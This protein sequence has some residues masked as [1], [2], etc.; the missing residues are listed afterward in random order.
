MK[1]SAEKSSATTSTTATQT[2]QHPF[3]GKS[4]RDSFFAPAGRTAAPAVQ[5]KMTL[6]KPGDK[7]EQ[8]ADKMADRV[9]RMPAPPAKEEKLQRQAEDRLPRQAMPEEKIRRKEEEKLQK[10]PAGDERLPRKG[11]DGAAPTVSD[12]VQS[13]VRSGAS[14]GG[15]PL[16]NEVRSYMEPRFGADFGNV[17][18]HNDAESAR[19]G[20]QL[21][22]RAFT[23]QNHVFFSRDQYQPGTSEGK[24]LLAHELGHTVQQGP[25]LQRQAAPPAA[26]RRE[27]P[28]PAIR[29]APAPA[30][31]EAVTSSEVVDLSSAGFNPSRKVSDEIEAQGHKGLDVRVMV[32]GLT[33][34][35]R[36]KTRSDRKGKN[37]SGKGSMP[38]LN[39][40]AE[41]LGGMHVNFVLKNGEVTGG[42][43][44]L[45]P[46]GGDTNDWLET[47][48][49]NSA[50]LGGPGLKVGSLPRPV[51]KFE[52]GK[53]TL[54][55]SDLKVE[56]GGFLDAKFNIAVED[57]KTPKIEASADINVKGIAKGQLKLDNLKGNLAGQVSLAVDH[58]SFSGAAIITYK[59]DGSVDIGGKAAYNADKLSG[60]VSFVATDLETANKFAKDAIAAAGGEKNVQDAGPPGPV[61]APKPGK[62]QR[63][64]AATGLLA[65]NL[66]QWFAGTVNVVVDGT[67]AVTVIGKIAP[68]GEILLFKEKNF[69]KEIFKLEAKAYYGIPVVGNLNLFANVS[70]TALAR[71][72]PAKIYNIEILGTYSTNPEIQKK[73]QISGSINISAY[74]GLRLRAEGGAGIEIASH[75]LKFGIGIQA[76]VGVK[77][78]ADARPTI[79]YRDPGVFYISGT[80]DLVAQP[81]LGLGGDFFIALETPWWS[82]LSD[83][84]WTWPLF[85]KEWPLSDPI[86]ISAVVKEYVFG[87]GQVPEIELKKPEFD[88]SKFMTSM[89]DNELPNKSGGKGGSGGTFKEDGSIPKPTV[90]PKKPEPKKADAKPTKKGAPPK[91]G[92]SAK[93]DPKAAKDQENNKIFQAAAKPLA[94]LKAR[95]PFNRAEL[96]QE[97]GKIKAQAKGISFDIEVKGE[98]WLVSPK[99]GGKKAKG[100]ELKAKDIGKEDGKIDGK[101]DERTDAQKL[102]DLKAAIKEATL[103]VDDEAK[104]RTEIERALP[105]IKTHYRLTTIVLVEV[106]EGE[107]AVIDSVTATVNPTISSHKK[108][109]RKPK[110]KTGDKVQIMYNGDWSADFIK[111]TKQINQY[112]WEAGGKID[113]NQVA[114]TLFARDY[115]TDWR[116]YNPYKTGDAW[117]AIKNLDAWS[118]SKDASQTLSYRKH[119]R[120][121]VPAGKNWHHIHEQGNKGPHTL[122]NIA[123]VDSGLNQGFLN[124]YFTKI[125]PGTQGMQL[126][127]FLRGES[128]E[129]HMEWG[130]RAIAAAGK[131]VTWNKD[132]GRGRYN[133]IG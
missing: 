84:R 45:K 127:H 29:R 89:V 43:A 48:K 78:Y 60:S 14:G 119:A 6:S 72:G 67:G 34:E 30:T 97:L 108:K 39:P 44:S 22:A 12:G 18:V 83:D 71:L 79:G 57:N 123:L 13:A 52:A 75:D 62:K 86:G 133:E 88:P 27:E 26:E 87:S 41:Q 106:A 40:W 105:A 63:A 31:K 8:D 16:S 95:G 3:F 126:R 77:A 107:D 102:T 90:P 116:K 61:P 69:D 111:V 25:A 122:P 15:E 120:F 128:H 125:Y 46:G 70:L 68:P 100:I 115:G 10:A 49:K 2:P 20:N 81:M 4:G 131:T 112:K 118:R 58:K 113:K 53:L 59:P 42:Y 9:M 32:K 132:E 33:G 51:N 92:K 121:N 35:G 21:E 28:S 80:L 73:I 23:Y 114:K 47:L 98:N 124:A 82:P 91:G 38:L 104:D 109:K 117:E 93:P 66:T 19:L 76:D 130:L 103:L 7:L 96:N 129:V 56:V 17:R 74:G 99:A 1:S 64:L 5:R 85:S 50:L 24:H 37:H 94:A 54:G 55:V 65:F 110:V 36:A 11:N 101:K